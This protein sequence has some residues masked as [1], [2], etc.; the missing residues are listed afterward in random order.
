MRISN[1]AVYGLHESLIASGYPMKAELPR[2]RQTLESGDIRG[3]GRTLASTPIGAGH[4]NFLNGIIVQFDIDW[5]IK[6]WTEAQR[7]HF[8]D[9]VSSMST[10]HRLAKMNLKE[11]FDNNVDPII[12]ARMVELQNE[13]NNIQDDSEGKQ[14][15]FLKMAFSCPVGLNLGAR[16]TTNYRQLKTIYAQRKNHRLPQWREFCKWVE[17]LP[18]MKELGI[19]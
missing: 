5:P 19:V 16:M 17:E 14:Q 6:L 1:W 8:L 4:D 15:A 3:R 9:F 12:I 7:Y 11:A 10:M 18:L 2:A 13:Y